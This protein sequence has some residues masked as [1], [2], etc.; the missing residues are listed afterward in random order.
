MNIL[1]TGGAGY[2]G[3]FMIKR[4]LEEDHKIVVL[5]NLERGSKDAIDKRAIFIKG[6]ILDTITLNNI[7]L[8]NKF[9]VII[10]FAGYISV[11]ES[12]KHP[13]LYF[14]NNT[15][16]SLN[17]I[18]TA[19]ENGVNNIIFSSTAGVYGKPVR[20]PIPEEH[21]KNPESPYGESKLLVEQLLNWYAKT[22]ALNY[23]ILRYFNV[24]GAALDSSLGKISQS[25][26]HIISN[27]MRT[28]LGKCNFELFGDNYE[29]K[30]GTCIRDYIHVLDL[31]EAHVLSIERLN[32]KPNCYTYNVGTGKGYSNL[33]VIEMVKKI[34]KKDFQVK[35]TNRRPGD[36]D[37]V[38]ADPEKIKK[39]LLFQPK[40]SNLETIIKT[41]WE[42]CK[43][44]Y[45]KLKPCEEKEKLD[46]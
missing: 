23:V 28:A 35:V 24:A 21:S 7:F 27:L 25:N 45:D 29:T 42:W 6:D 13:Y 26:D 2:I 10:H 32:K 11:N 1:V 20:T 18:N 44:S 37:A 30:D 41:E 17:L 38:I 3:S 40:Y 31:V 9:D 34:T 15:Y 22:K 43:K 8:K 39:E 5:D 33:E 16:G 12:I 46:I 19:I 36:V 4:L 14:Q